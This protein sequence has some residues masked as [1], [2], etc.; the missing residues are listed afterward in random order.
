[1]QRL[2]R[3]MGIV[4]FSLSGLHSWADE[5]GDGTSAEIDKRINIQPEQNDRSFR[6]GNQTIEEF[7][8]GDRLR[9]MKI[10]P[11]E[12]PAYY[13]KDRRGD[14]RLDEG[15]DSMEEDVNLRKWR[16]GQW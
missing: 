1:M 14:G 12:A 6:L 15:H 3:I 5:A 8:R 16:L 4:L 7:H 9:V 11:D 13:L 2:I 10:D